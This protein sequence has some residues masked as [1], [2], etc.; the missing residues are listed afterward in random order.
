MT[1]STKNK[2]KGHGFSESL[3]KVNNRLKKAA[4]LNRHEEPEDVE[5][6]KN[7]KMVEDVF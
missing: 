4:T 7:G 3:A 5:E 1:L 6:F 2:S